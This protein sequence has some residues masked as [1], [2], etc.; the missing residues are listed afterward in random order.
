[1]RART[2]VCT[3]LLVLVSAL[4][5]T[6]CLNYR[7]GNQFEGKA[8]YQYQL[9]S[10]YEDPES[11]DQGQKD[12]GKDEK[13]SAT[14][15][16]ATAKVKKTTWLKYVNTTQNAATGERLF[17]GQD[18]ISVHLKTA[19]FNS[20]PESIWEQRQNRNRPIHG[21]VAIV[22]NIS[23][24]PQAPLTDPAGPGNPGRV[25][26]YSGELKE[27]QF[28]NESFN[29]MYGPIAYDGQPLTIDLTVVEIDAKERTQ[30]NALLDTLA[31]LGAGRAGVGG[32]ALNI[33]TKL[34]AALVNSNKDD[35]LGHYR[36]TLMPSYSRGKADVPL[37]LEGDYVITRVADTTPYPRWSDLYYDSKQGRLLRCEENKETKKRDC[38]TSGA[39]DFI[40][41]TIARDASSGPGATVTPQI[42]LG[43]LEAE[44]IKAES[45]KQMTEAITDAM[46]ALNQQVAFAKAR[47]TLNVIETAANGSAVKSYAAS[48][49]AELLLC[50]H[51]A[52]RRDKPN[53]S[54]DDVYATPCG[55]EGY[56]KK[57][58]SEQEMGFVVR[59]ISDLQCSTPV[60]LTPEALKVGASDF[61]AKSKALHDQLI[62]CK[63]KEP[64]AT[65]TPA[66]T[67]TPP[68]T[69][70]PAKTGG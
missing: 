39:P 34:G 56:D 13:A 36:V 41:F 16:K 25:V 43:D 70:T 6:G 3:A 33:L 55:G 44:I 58:L 49:L 18:I 68:K 59:R 69:E 38:F 67:E 12:A 5:A 52:N 47:N 35:V 7:Y 20:I 29:T 23:S 28:I 19:R 50:G 45:P 42:T 31:K 2:S 48:D 53:K 22:A 11:A 4:L 8:D 64:A 63:A 51:G 37:L 21:E 65:E 9:E 57:A 27:G 30:L 17:H 26:F 1:M 15:Q 10:T 60:S 54:T 66:K 62:T 32:T 61:A 24:G 40:A 46:L 14:D